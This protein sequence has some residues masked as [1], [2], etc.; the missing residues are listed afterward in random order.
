MGLS[1]QQRKQL[2]SAL[3]DAF[4]TTA[5]LEQMLAFG[6]DKNLRAIAGEGSLQDIIFKLIQ[7]AN[8]EGWVED[9]VRAARDSN[10]GNPQLKAIAEG[11][12]NSGAETPLSIPQKPTHQVQT[13]LILAAIPKGL[14]L[15]TEISPLLSLSL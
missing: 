9:L 2:Q 1:G 7:V 6:L 8:A 4:P 3:I 5:S 10:P 15:D 14:R 12:P 13:I 11:L